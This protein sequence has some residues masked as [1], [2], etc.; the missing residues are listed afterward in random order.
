MPRNRK[1]ARGRPFC[2]D[3]MF[4]DGMRA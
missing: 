2:C 3:L 4:V 1:I